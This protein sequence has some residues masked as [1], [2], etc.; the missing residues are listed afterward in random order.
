LKSE[1]TPWFSL[2]NNIPGIKDSKQYTQE[3]GSLYQGDWAGPMP[4]NSKEYFF[5]LLDARPGRNE[6]ENINSTIEQQFAENHQNSWLKNFIEQ[7]K[8][9]LGVKTFLNG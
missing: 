8:K 1:E 6:A 3:L 2:S 9:L 7:Q 5:E 4:I